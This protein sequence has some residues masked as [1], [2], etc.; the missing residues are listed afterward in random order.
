MHRAAWLKLIDSNVFFIAVDNIIMYLDLRAEIGRDVLMRNITE[1]MLVSVD[2]AGRD[3][4]EMT[5]GYIRYS[6]CY[7]DNVR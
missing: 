3:V 4:V 7:D 1:D 6:L 5:S 2:T